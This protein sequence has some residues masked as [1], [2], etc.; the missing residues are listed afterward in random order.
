[1]KKCENGMVTEQKLGKATNKY[2]VD[3]IDKRCILY[4]VYCIRNWNILKWWQN[5]ETWWG[6]NQDEIMIYSMGIS[7]SKNGATVPYKAICCG[8]IPLHR[9]KK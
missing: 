9:P 3:W 4:T 7:G 1:M 8:D 5:E 2:T 6:C